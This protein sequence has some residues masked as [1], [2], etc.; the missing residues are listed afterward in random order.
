MKKKII[1]G[2]LLAIAALGMIFFGCDLFMS[3][4]A[5]SPSTYD[6]LI[7]PARGPNGEEVEI[8]FSTTRKPKAVLTPQTGD[9]YVMR[10]DGRVISQGTVQ[11][12]EI[13]IT[14]RP[15]NGAPAFVGSYTR[16]VAHIDIVLFEIPDENG[17]L[18]G[19][20]GPSVPG[21]GAGGG[22]GGG[23]GPTRPTYDV[24]A[25]SPTVVI[26]VF[27]SKAVGGAGNAVNL[28]GDTRRITSNVAIYVP[29]VVEREDSGPV[30]L[31]VD[32]RSEVMIAGTGSLTVNPGEELI[33]TGGGT[34][35]IA[36][37]ALNI[38]GE[39]AKLTVD[40]GTKL[41]I[42]NEGSNPPTLNINDNGELALDGGDIDIYTA[43]SVRSTSAAPADNPATVKVNSGN[44]NVYSGGYLT[45]GSG[46]VLELGTSSSSRPPRLNISGTGVVEI[47]ED[48][49]WLPED[50]TPAASPLSFEGVTLRGSGELI[51]PSGPTE[52]TLNTVISRIKRIDRTSSYQGKVVVKLTT[53]FYTGVNAAAPLKYIQVDVK[54]NSNAAK[55]DVLENRVPYTIRG[56][57]IGEDD[58]E[59]K[60]GIWLAND[61]ITL[62]NVKFNITTA[63]ASVG[64]N[65]DDGI[66]PKTPFRNTIYSAAVMIG[67]KDTN[68]MAGATTNLIAYNYA[69]VWYVTVRNCDITFTGGVAGTGFTAGIWVMARYVTI[70]GNTV[71][72]ISSSVSAVQALA[73]IRWNDGIRIINNK[74]LTAK[75]AAG[76]PTVV[77]N[78]GD[79]ATYFIPASA[80]FVNSIFERPEGYPGCVISGNTLAYGNSNNNAPGNSNTQGAC[81]SFFI[82]TATASIADNNTRKGIADMRKYHFSWDDST[83][84][85][86]P[87]EQDS[88]DAKRLVT[89]LMNNIRST[90]GNGFGAIFLYMQG[91][92]DNAVESY[93]IK[94]GEVIR[95][96]YW[97]YQVIN[98]NDVFEGPGGD[99]YGNITFNPKF[100]DKTKL[101]GQW[102]D[103]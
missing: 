19:E 4:G 65:K 2:V 13:H 53:G 92:G 75:F 37:T 28:T 55:P 49:A 69:D 38:S 9:S 81:F 102:E 98:G 20:T 17:N 54:E 31:I 51:V 62:E 35:R 99:E 89:M 22:G 48:G 96:S 21:G 91:G 26:G 58:L 85:L 40:T 27:G 8:E 15:G 87:L 67:R 76:Y 23:G 10:I 88:S 33:V 83:W 73:F 103:I 18:P 16:G 78:A 32:S 71:T 1:L 44:V 101:I 84:V 6:P 43:V 95:I 30:K 66:V 74:K 7:I 59:L 39:D 36:G 5:G 42:A 60:V 46:G 52:A 34:L 97:G 86:E 94:D 90:G 93:A 100:V 24:V 79:I 77:G 29:I 50:D 63:A 3:E 25:R 45:I 80:I 70:E 41:I 68:N 11:I 12:D 64:N 82:N 61:N 57:G 56:R 14:F 72:A 47:T